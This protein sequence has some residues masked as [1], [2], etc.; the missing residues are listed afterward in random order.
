MRTQLNRYNICVSDADGERYLRLFGHLRADGDCLS[1]VLSSSHQD[2]RLPASQ[3]LALHAACARVAH[4]SGAA[5]FFNEIDRDVE[6]STVLAFD[7][8]S[9]RLLNHLISPFATIPGVVMCCSGIWLFLAV[10]MY[11]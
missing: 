6:E 5:E 11:A 4:M 7:G 3:L 2:A 10:S 9:V 8:S 1:T